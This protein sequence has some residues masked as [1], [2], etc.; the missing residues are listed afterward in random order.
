MKP[1]GIYCPSDDRRQAAATAGEFRRSIVSSGKRRFGRGTRMMG[2]LLVL[3][4]AFAGGPPAASGQGVFGDLFRAMGR[5]IAPERD[6]PRELED[7]PLE[8]IQ[9]A[10]DFANQFT[11]HLKKVLNTE[12]HF[13]RH[14][15]QPS[16][17]QFAAIH[18]AGEESVQRVSKYLA[19]FAQN[20]R[21]NAD[22]PSPRELISKSLAESI[23]SIVDEAAA[24][25]YRHELEARRQDRREAAVGGLV[26][27]IDRE[28]VLAP[29]QIEPI[30]KVLSEN[31]NRDWNNLS[32]LLLYEQYV[33]F[34]PLDVLRPHLTERQRELWRLLPDRP[35]IHF[36]WQMELQ[37]RDFIG[38]Q[39]LEPLDP[40]PPAERPAAA[41]PAE[42]AP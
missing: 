12:L 23:G 13:V 19:R 30:R 35:N 3:A 24:E 37:V 29:E 21:V 27:M 17:V 39:D 26:C 41:D 5:A 2:A 9:V 15:C 38:G 14:I 11:P 20:P 18:R 22:W 42:A 16:D 6:V 1:T 4:V 28:L 36:G 31:W 7:V 25:S 33:A 10:P 32:H 34:P 40:P 8:Q